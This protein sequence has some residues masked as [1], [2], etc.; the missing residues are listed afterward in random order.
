VWVY[1][2]GSPGCERLHQPTDDTP[3]VLS[4]ETVLP[5][6]EVPV[7]NYWRKFVRMDA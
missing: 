1:R 3:L 4:G 7:W 5:G 6:L 2:E